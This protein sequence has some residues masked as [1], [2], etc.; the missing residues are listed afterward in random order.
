VAAS[1]AAAFDRLALD[2]PIARDL[3]TVV[4]CGAAR[5]RLR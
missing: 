1:W 3:L 4:A 2:D 5:S